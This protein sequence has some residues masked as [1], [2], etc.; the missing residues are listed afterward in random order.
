MGWFGGGLSWVR[1]DMVMWCWVGY[2]GVGSGTRWRHDMVVCW[3]C[4]VC[5]DVTWC[6]MWFSIVLR[7]VVF[8]CGVPCRIVLCVEGQSGLEVVEGGVGYL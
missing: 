2:G 8:C 4:V 5:C 6:V 1:R 7:G 3:C